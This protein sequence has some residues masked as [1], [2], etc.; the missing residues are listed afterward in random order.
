MQEVGSRAHG[1][2]IAFG[3]VRAQEGMAPWARG[4]RR[5]EL[6]LRLYICAVGGAAKRLGG[7]PGRRRFPSFEGLR[8]SGVGMAPDGAEASSLD[9]CGRRRGEALGG[10]T[11]SK[12]AAPAGASSQ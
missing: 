12:V 9:L 8:T 2:S 6:K 1:S 3:R 11:V 4:W 7:V 5:T 10:A